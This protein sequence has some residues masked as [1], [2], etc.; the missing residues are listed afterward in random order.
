MKD[1]H[2][3]THTCTGILT[4]VPC[5]ISTS[6]TGPSLGEEE[7]RP[8]L[9]LDPNFLVNTRMN[10]HVSGLW[11]R[12]APQGCL[13]FQSLTFST[14]FSSLVALPHGGAWKL[15]CWPPEASWHT[16]RQNDWD[17]FK[18]RWEVWLLHSHI[19]AALYIKLK[20]GYCTGNTL[21]EE[22]IFYF[23]VKYLAFLFSEK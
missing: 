10:T 19:Y 13:P 22:M 23:T 2:T 4:D 17:F 3:Y 8:C 14:V 5:P 15:N 12:P 7:G 18:L 20:L 1:L 11:G 6:H 9:L 21:G 16:R